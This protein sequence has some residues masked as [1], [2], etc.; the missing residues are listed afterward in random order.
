VSLQGEGFLDRRFS[1]LHRLFNNSILFAAS[2][3]R[4]KFQSMTKA[5][6]QRNRQKG[7]FLLW[8]TATIVYE[9]T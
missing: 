8:N 2:L 7:A 3:V 4:Q 5:R 1:T 9:F 6:S